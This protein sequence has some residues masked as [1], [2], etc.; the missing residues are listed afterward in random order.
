M[1]VHGTQARVYVDGQKKPSLVVTDLKHGASQGAIGVSG[2]PNGL[3]HFANFTYRLDDDLGF[4][5]PPVFETAHGTVTDWQLSQSFKLSAVDPERYPNDKTLSRITWKPVKSEQPGLVNVSRYVTRSGAEPE[6]VY[7]KATLTVNEDVRKKLLIGY[8]DVVTVHLNG[9]TL[10]SGF[11]D[12]RRRDNT[13]LGVMGLN[14]VLYLPLKKGDNELLLAVA[15]SFA[16]WGFMARDGGAIYQRDGVKKVWETEGEFVFPESAVYDHERDCIYITNYDMY[17]RSRSEGKQFISRV[18]LDGTVEKREWVGGLK[19]PTGMVPHEDKLYI[20]ERDAVAVV[21]LE[22][23]RI[24]GRHTLQ[25]ARF[26][27]DIAMTPDGVIYVSD[28]AGGTLFRIADGEVEPWL[29]DDALEAPNAIFVHDGRLLVGTGGDHA[30]KSI[31][32][33]TK[34]IRTIVTFGDGFIDGIKVDGSG[35]Y[36]VSHWEGRLYRVTPSGDVTKL[37]DT[38]A[39]EIKCADFD[40]IPDRDLVIVPTMDSGSV[41]AYELGSARTTTSN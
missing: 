4:E 8:S 20:V 37:L 19:N 34:E 31:D 26:P 1:E 29:K 38:S 35:N 9:E 17:H 15:E 5:S 27:N 3:A 30:L 21:D 36:L 2:P 40:Y 28:S 23:G 41:K 7:A 32:L 22:T 24:E 13:F 10:F 33:A 18:S 16:G 14:D 11:S 39:P 25:G 12:F 6:V